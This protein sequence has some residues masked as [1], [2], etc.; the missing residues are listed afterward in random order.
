[1]TRSRYIALGALAL[2]AGA[3]SSLR[4]Q[5]TQ[6]QLAFGYE[7]GDRFLVRNE[8]TTPVAIE[9]AIAGSQDKSQLHLNVR[10]SAEIASAQ[11][12]NMEL[13]VGGKV[14]ASE[15]KGNRACGAAQNSGGVTV[16]PLDQNAQAAAQPMDS[17]YAAAPV[18]VYAPP[19]AY[20]YYPY[21]YGYY[22]YG[23]GY[24]GYAPYYYPSIGIYGRGFVGRVGG[25]RGRGRR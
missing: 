17:A 19:P 15:P 18:V 20:D 16:R 4:A 8:G 1:M 23:Y 7:C 14:V 13:W 24:F 9:Y 21:A 10:Q 12:G 25:F 3:S 2:L 22:P 5:T 6:V 11:S